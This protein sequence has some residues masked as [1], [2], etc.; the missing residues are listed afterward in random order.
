M[1]AFL[2]L[3][4]ADSRRLR[5]FSGGADLDGA[6]RAAV[7]VSYPGSYGIVATRGDDRIIAHATYVT[8]T[9]DRAE[10]AFT[11]ADELQGMGIATTLLAHLA[12]AAEEGGI[13]WFEAEVL[14]ENHRMVGVFRDSG[15]AVRTHSVPGAIHLEFPTTLGPEARRRFDERESLAAA[16]AVRSFLVPSSLAGCESPSPGCRWA[17][18]RCRRWGRA[19]RSSVSSGLAAASVARRGPAVDNSGRCAG[20]ERCPAGA[21][22]RTPP[23]RSVVRHGRARTRHRC[24][25]APSKRD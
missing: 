17:S 5:Y 4:S 21:G 7:G 19:H 11:V 24:Q 16:A 9:A 15:F 1:R 12:E 13:L 14:P 22:R 20:W 3:L 18:R 10:V 23:A 8:A 2:G 6:A 25:R